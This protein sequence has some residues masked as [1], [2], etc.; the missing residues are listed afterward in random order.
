MSGKGLVLKKFFLKR[1]IYKSIKSPI[2]KIGKKISRDS[3]PKK[4]D[5]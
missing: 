1:H 3:S 4:I 2:F 5:R